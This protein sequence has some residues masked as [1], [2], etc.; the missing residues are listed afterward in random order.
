M[1][2]KKAFSEK[3]SMSCRD[4]A[5]LLSCPPRLLMFLAMLAVMA[6]AAGCA[7]TPWRQPIAEDRQKLVLQVID[8]M[9]QEEAAR[10]DCIDSDLDL[11]ISSRMKNRAVR[12]YL[13]LKQPESIKF[14][15]SNPLGQPLLAFTSDGSRVQYVNT[16]EQFFADGDIAAFAELYEIP[17]FA[18]T[19]SWGKWLTGRL[20]ATSAITAVRQ[21]ESDRGFWVS[22]AGD[23]EAES[24]K[25]GKP[26]VEHLLIDLDNRTML[27]RIFTDSKGGIAARIS[28]SDWLQ[29][30]SRH[31]SRQPGKITITDLDYGAEIVL[32]F[33]ALQPMEN[34]S[35]KDFNLSKPAGYRY[36][37]VTSAGN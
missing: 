21:D 4:A 37:P 1:K 35:S 9:R 13:Q 12:G 31:I 33:S 5:T 3:N 26:A 23:G 7:R 17:A 14:I 8:E 6:T 25:A 16:F 15:T 29:N 19:S 11:F 18:Y 10:S 34:C 27:G 36:A 20:P 30:S 24:G 28:Y 32:K 2:L 22:F